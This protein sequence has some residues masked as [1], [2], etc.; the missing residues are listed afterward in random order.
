MIKFTL[1][2]GALPFVLIGLL[3]G[4]ADRRYD[5]DSSYYGD[6][7]YPRGSTYRNTTTDAPVR[8]G[9]REGVREGV[10]DTINP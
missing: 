1:L 2:A 4:C 7:D 3:A 9:V 8:Q 6:R 5:R 10:R